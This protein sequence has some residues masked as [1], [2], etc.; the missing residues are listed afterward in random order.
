MWGKCVLLCVC[1]VVWMYCCMS[2][3]LSVGVII[4]LLFMGYLS[5]SE[6]F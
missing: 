6:R 5:V 4:P 3:L 2:V 1:A